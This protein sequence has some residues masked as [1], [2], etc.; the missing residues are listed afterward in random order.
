MNP[1]G[2]E[3]RRLQSIDVLNLTLIRSPDHNGSG[4]SLEKYSQLKQEQTG[5]HLLS[6]HLIFCLLWQEA[7]VE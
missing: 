1:L 2:K 5:I 4:R 7:V 3:E 6:C